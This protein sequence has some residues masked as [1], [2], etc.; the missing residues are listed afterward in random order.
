[1]Y[2]ENNDI[3]EET[4]F[5][6]G[7]VTKS[8]TALSIYKEKI[9]INQTLDKF[10][11][12]KKYIDEEYAKEITISELLNHTSGLLSFGPN[13][14]NKQGEM[15]YSNYGF[16]LLGKILEHKTNKTYFYY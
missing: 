9:D 7:S 16:A 3:T 11:Y 15:S 6:I 4:P 2:S 8:F 5:L 14:I 12:L 13:R 1:M 10:D